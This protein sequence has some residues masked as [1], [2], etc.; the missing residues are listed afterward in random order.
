M[1]TRGRLY[2]CK[3][4]NKQFPTFQALGGHRASHK[5]PRLMELYSKLDDRTASDNQNQ[6]KKQKI[7]ECSVCG[8]KFEIGQ[9]LGGH[10]RRHRAAMIESS[11]TREETVPRTP[12]SG[13]HMQRLLS[14]SSDNTNISFQ[15]EIVRQVP[16]LK[17]SNSSRRV[18]SS[19][20]DLSLSILP[21]YNDSPP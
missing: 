7:H 3:T 21:L 4:C 18:L 8:L 13:G 10:M 9:A 12:G 6:V 19:N 15:E 20:L 14:S 17:R 2:E 5:K 11:S 1:P 16:I